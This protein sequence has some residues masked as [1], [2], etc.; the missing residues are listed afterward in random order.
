MSES[1]FSIIHTSL[2]I[3]SGRNPR[4]EMRG[5]EEFAENIKEYDILEPI[6][7]RPKEDKFEVVVG[8]RRVRASI[9]AGIKEIPAIIRTLTDRQSDELRLIENTQRE[10]LTNAEKGD[11]VYALLENYPEKYQTT[12]SVSDKINVP[13]DT[14]IKWCRYSRKVSDYVKNVVG[15]D[16]LGE[17]QVGYLVKYNHPTQEKLAK[18]IVE[19]KLTSEQS[20]KFFRLYEANPNANRKREIAGDFSTNT[21]IIH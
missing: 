8:E 2:L 9:L 12:K 5:L 17:D 4:T 16:N 3:Y 7:V 19:H 18:M 1:E 6:I 20:R 15:A 13:Y 14:V 11:A 21:C 10:D